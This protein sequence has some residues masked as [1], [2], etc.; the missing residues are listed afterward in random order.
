MKILKPVMA[1]LLSMALLVSAWAVADRIGKDSSE[2]AVSRLS[3]AITQA[4]ATCYA[5]EGRYPP[6]VAYLEENYAIVVD[7]GMLVVYEAFG[8]NVMP[9]VKVFRR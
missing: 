4:C 7:E 6:D 2:K 5:L 8:E 9:V 3:S 1:A